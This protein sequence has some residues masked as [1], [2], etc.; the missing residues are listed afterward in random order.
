MSR[1]PSQQACTLGKPQFN[2]LCRLYNRLIVDEER[3]EMNKYELQ[4]LS[5]AKKVEKLL[6]YLDEITN[7]NW[8]HPE[9]K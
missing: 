8:A 4:L 6:L 7:D 2:L 9:N 3:I 1:Q 5:S